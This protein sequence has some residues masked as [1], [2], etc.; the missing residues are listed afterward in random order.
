[1]RPLTIITGILLGSAFSIALGL[2][3]VMLIF[4][5]IGDENPSVYGEFKPLAVTTAMFTFLT[6][7]SALSFVALLKNHRFWWCGQLAMWLSVFLIGRYFW[8]TGG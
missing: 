8:P 6:A 4:L 7:V 2:S 3:V 1:M 5:I